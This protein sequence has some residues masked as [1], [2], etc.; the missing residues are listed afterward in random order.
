[1][2]QITPLVK[3]LKAQLKANGCTYA[4]VA[5]QLGLSEAS[6]K[7]LFAEESFT[8]QRL[9]DVCHMIGL[10]ISELIQ[11]MESEQRKIIQLS[12]EQ[13]E[14]IAADLLLLMITACVINGYSYQD[15]IEQY[16]IK[17]TDC[18]QKLVALD[19]LKIIELLPNN[20]IKLL[21]SHNFSWQPNGP[22]QRFFQEKI[23]QD[24]FSSKFDQAHEK[25][26]VINGLLSKASNIEFQK[27][28]QRLAQDFTELSQQDFSLP[29]EEKYGNSI[30]LAVRQWQY[31]LFEAYKK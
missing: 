10:E 26:I 15:L 21:I 22:I 13:E 11:L 25:L 28:L 2:P 1:M 14:Q 16:D 17:P 5:A 30:V 9:E 19:R 7:R 4:N 3:T 23:E 27:K 6:V 20:R 18:I 12:L 24:F 29:M 31:N 8:L